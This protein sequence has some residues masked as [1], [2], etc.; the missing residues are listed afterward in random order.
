MASV[1]VVVYFILLRSLAQALNASLA[2]KRCYL[3]LGGEKVNVLR[4]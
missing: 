2:A 3:P 4:E 1:V